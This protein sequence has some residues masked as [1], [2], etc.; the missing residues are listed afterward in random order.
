MDNMNKTISENTKVALL[1]TCIFNSNEQRQ[2]KILT[3]N[4]YG[5]FAFWL[6]AYKYELADLLQQDK[7]GTILAHWS[8]ADSHPIIKK[9]IALDR[10][11]R[12]IADITPARIQTLLGRG[13]S[14]S[15]ALDKWTAAGIWVL[16]R[17]DNNYPKK[18]KQ[19]LKHQSPAILFGV[20]NV[21]LLAKPAIGFVGS[22]D[23]EA[24]DQAATA[25]YVN[26]INQNGFQ[27]VS[28]AAKGV[29]SHAMLASL[30]N[31][32]S[33]IGIVADSLFKA[34]VNKQ[35]REYLK[36][37]QLVLI[38]PFY[39]ESKF[40][41]ADAMARNKFIYLLSSATVVIRSGE[42]GGTWKGAEENLK[43]GWVPLMVSEHK[44]PNYP[45]NQALLD[46]QIT[47]A[48][49]QAQKITP[50]LSS[51]DFIR[52]LNEGQSSQVA[53]QVSQQTASSS[54]QA[55]LLD[56]TVGGDLFDQTPEAVKAPEYPKRPV[57]PLTSSYADKDE[58]DFSAM[59]SDE[60]PQIIESP[61]D[62]PTEKIIEQRK[63]PRLTEFENDEQETQEQ[64]NSLLS[65]LS[66]SSNDDIESEKT[67]VIDPNAPPW[68]VEKT[69]STTLETTSIES[70]ESDDSTVSLQ[71][72]PDDLQAEIENKPTLSPVSHALFEQIS[73]LIEASTDKKISHAQIE[74][75]LPECA[76]LGKAALNKWIK[77]LLEQGYLQQ[78]TRK[79][80]YSIVS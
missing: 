16:A 40:S 54:Q 59:A 63:D 52:L 14:L 66:N 28:G 6:R 21:E 42:T 19:A 50:A 11:D 17:S 27:V 7:L 10:L 9:N 39:P 18:I 12:T 73:A 29:D 43:K 67:D 62:Q 49:L 70:I 45:A 78:P 5:Y 26:A 4:G 20:G 22:R 68:E 74:S 23:C 8:Q 46:G 53:Q 80:E 61:I 60:E 31:G 24:Q 77:H 69:I 65:N 25:H 64:P 44:S 56:E 2:C 34:S 36:S 30:S 32:H 3:P 33:S 35:W 57:R 38:T 47:K 55:S 71:I 1:L 72:D 15:M 51:D 48:K 58:M 79:K 13:A 75:E 76:I 37:E 41:P